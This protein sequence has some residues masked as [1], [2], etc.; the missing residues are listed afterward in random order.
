VIKEGDLAVHLTDADHFGAS[1]LFATGSDAHLRELQG[2][3]AEK[4]LTLTPAG[5]RRGSRRL[6][7]KTEPQIYKTLGLQYIEPELC[8]GR[9]EIARARAGKIP[10]L[11][12]REDIRGVLH[13][14]TDA[15]DGVNTLADMAEAARS[16]GY[17]Y[18]GITDHSRTAHYAGGL[19]I[20]EIEAQQAEI[21][22]LNQGF[23]G[24]FRIFKGI[25]SD[26]LADGSLDYPDGVLAQFDFIIAS[27][28]SQFRMDKDAQTQRL[29]RAIAN[30]YVTII[31]HL[32]GR[33]LLR[34]PGYELDIE[35]ILA[36][37]AEH[38]V[39]IEINGNP[40][41]LDLDWRWHQRALDMGCLFSI[42]PD[43]HSIPEIDSSTRW[44]VAMARKGGV[45]TKDVLNAL[46]AVEFQGWLARRQRGR[47]VNSSPQL[48]GCSGVAATLRP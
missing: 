15:S 5:L 23:A 19:T 22:R 20:A 40:W 32:T 35:P 26:I 13:A 11:V 44:G 47:P 33:Q 30:P 24:D 27:V 9:G 39:A 12:G 8:E 3:A 4:G 37:C 28:H 14:H 2:V 42:N 18:I 16:R 7:S 1:L 6:G 21:G 25:E 29:L 38:C 41:R 31:G 48:S 17:Q 36:A 46:P 10:R 43:A 45:S 34:R